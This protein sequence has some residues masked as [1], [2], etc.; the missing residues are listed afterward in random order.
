MLSTRTRIKSATVRGICVKLLR[1]GYVQKE[2]RG[3]YSVP[4]GIRDL[5]DEE[6]RFE[7][8]FLIYVVNGQVLTHSEEKKDYFGLQIQITC[9]VSNNQVSC[10]LLSTE[11]KGF[12]LRELNLAVELFKA[13]L[14]KMLGL[15]V[16][17]AEIMVKN[18]EC[19]LDLIRCRL[20]G[21]NAVT[22]QNFNVE[23]LKFY[24]KS[25]P[26]R[27]RVEIISS[28]EISIESLLDRLFQ[29]RQVQ[30]QNSVLKI[31]IN[32]IQE[33]LKSIGDLFS[34]IRVLLSDVV[35]TNKA[36]EKSNKQLESILGSFKTV[37]DN[38]GVS[39][40]K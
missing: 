6:P 20:E 19:N 34:D 35:R 28:R 22:I 17:N 32:S 23:I 15:I 11:S 36:V 5:S 21:V 8:I 13:H 4:G 31:E 29:L 38:T 37:Y 30:M 40:N 3:L 16:S 25:N 9:G 24:N 18:F 1:E 12:V 26:E 10:R 14:E 27:L 2:I 33:N 39:R 7:N